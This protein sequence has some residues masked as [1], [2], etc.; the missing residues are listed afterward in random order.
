[1][2]SALPGDVCVGQH[3]VCLVRAAIL[4]PDCA[5]LGGADTGIITAGIVTATASPELQEGQSFEVTTGCGDLAWTFEQAD[6]IRRWNVNGELAFFDHEMYY[7]LFGGEVLVGGSGS[8]FAGD[9]IGWASPNFTDSEPPAVYLEF[10]TRTAASGVGECATE[11]G[12]PVP[13]YVG[14]IF[15][16]AKL[17]PGDRTFAAEAATVA[18][19]G[20][21]QNNPNLGTGPWADWPGTGNVRNTGYQQISYSQAEYEAIAE[22]AACGWQ[23][24]PTGS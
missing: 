9:S 11:T 12:D 15:G 16:R 22:L 6:K 20:F 8:D 10:I 18:F 2:A 13:A 7:V 3:S 1:M 4:G 24:V 23:T 14:H 17:V 19:T 5:P 21:S